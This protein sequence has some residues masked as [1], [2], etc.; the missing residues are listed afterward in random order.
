MQTST[1]IL[2]LTGIIAVLVVTVAYL[3][4]RMARKNDELRRKNEVIVREIYHSQ[5]LIE[6]A[7]RHGVSRAAML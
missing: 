6:R 2:L 1:L 4:G 3:C 5:D 7:V